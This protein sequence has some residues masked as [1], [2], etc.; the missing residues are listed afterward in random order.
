MTLVTFDHARFFSAVDTA[1]LLWNGFAMPRFTLTVA[2]QIAAY[3]DELAAEH[4]DC[5]E[6]L[7]WIEELASFAVLKMPDWGDEDD[8][9]RHYG[10]DADHLYAIGAGWWTWDI[11]GPTERVPAEL[12]EQVRTAIH[13]DSGDAEASALW[14]LAEWAGIDTS[15]PEEKEGS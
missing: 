11:A 13:G 2:K 8:G 15:E 5:T 1:D 14:A 7:I 4:P 3:C 12:V 10:P 9:G 6:R